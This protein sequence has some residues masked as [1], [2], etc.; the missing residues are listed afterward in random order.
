MLELHYGET[1]EKIIVTLNELITLADP[2]Y[3]FV[4]THVVTRDVVSF[5]KSSAADE[6]AY[7]ERYNQF[8]IDT[9]D[10]FEDQQ[11]G[12]WHY[13]IYEQS[14]NSNTDPDLATGLIESGKMI[15]YPSTAFEYTKYSQST[16]FK[17][18]NG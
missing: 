17:T 12:E 10:V 13:E 6:S 18:Y 4:F 9:S 2:D 8:D 1:S 14:S 15:L 16:T 5:V 3:L 7:P 11:P